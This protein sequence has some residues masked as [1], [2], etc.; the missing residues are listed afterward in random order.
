MAS[1]HSCPFCKISSS[2]LPIAPSS[3]LSDGSSSPAS[4][5]SEGQAHL[6][7]STKH[8]LAFLDIMPLTRGHLLLITREHCEKLNEVG[9]GKWLPIISRVVTRTVLGKDAPQSDMHWNVVQ[10]NGARAAQLVPHVH[11]HIIPR[12][13]TDVVPTGT[14]TSWVMF[15]RGQRDDLDDEEGEQLSQAMRAELAKE[16]IHIRESE[17]IDL[18][19]DSEGR[20]QGK[21]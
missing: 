13:N 18:D 20:S 5:S 9:L 15:G 7:L 11:F 16:V 19:V 17:G 8:V 3:F 4:I 2:Y 21:L 6:V 14:K 10:N 12:P 1:H